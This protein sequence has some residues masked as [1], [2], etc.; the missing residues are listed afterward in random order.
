M[1]PLAMEP[2]IQETEANGRKRTHTEFAGDLQEPSSDASAKPSGSVS[3]SLSHCSAQPSAAG[4]AAVDD[5]ACSSP[6][7][8]SPRQPLSPSDATTPKRSADKKQSVSPSAT[9][10]KT[11]TSASK[12][13][14]KRKRLTGG[15]KEA[16]DR[17]LAEKKKEKE[18]Q[19]ALRA[20]EKARQEETKAARAKDREEKRK[21]KEEE[22]EA[23]AERKRQKEEE[24]RRILEDKDKKARSQTKLNF[25]SF[26]KT[27]KKTASTTSSLVNP[28]SAEAVSKPEPSTYDKLFPPFY[29]GANVRWTRVVGSMDEET[30][31]AKSDGLD[32]YIGG[33]REPKEHAGPLDTVELLGLPSKPPKRG[34]LH[35]PVRHIMEKC[36]EEAT[37]SG[38]DIA[39]AERNVEL[40]RERL[41]KI[42]RKII[43]FHQDVRPPYR[44]TITFVPQAMGM[45]NMYRLARK[46]TDKRIPGIDYGYDS[47]AEWQDEEGEDVDVDDDDEEQDDEDD[48]DG[49]L[50]DSEDAGLSRRVF[51][52]TM[53]PIS[54]G[55]SF[56]NEAGRASNPGLSKFKMEFMHAG[57]K[58]DWGINP[59]SAD[60]WEPEEKRRSPKTGNSA[61]G[62]SKMA[63]PKTQ[64]A[65]ALNALR[66]GEEKTGMKMVKAEHLDEVK[67]LILQYSDVSKTAIIE[68]IL[69]EFRSKQGSVS[70]A[71]VKNTVEKIAEKK[72]RHEWILRP[73]Y[74]IKL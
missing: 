30:K 40:V 20:A 17:E 72:G 38:N 52:K 18:A 5:A 33:R 26:P 13:A 65:N 68:V 73:G 66:D 70:R 10:S 14:V 58:Q 27:A 15:E 29:V 11:I 50:D 32:E 74:E 31:K 56:E 1:T 69:H 36:F 9:T 3:V 64:A 45:G 22:D 51:A 48:M 55:I 41:A 39:V 8:S 67:R 24:Q 49:F 61:K 42:P 46:T 12:P 34:R 60:Y 19:A 53:E 59:F 37:R 21:K 63:P 54:S 2:N 44:G 25:H 47:E 57:L 6:A 4:S 16:R 28:D 35:H 7:P 62:A 23:K 71:E 43:S